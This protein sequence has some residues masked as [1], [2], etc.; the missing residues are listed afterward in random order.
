[1]SFLKTSFRLQPKAVRVATDCGCR[2]SFELKRLYVSRLAADAAP[3]A[4]DAVLGWADL[5]EDVALATWGFEMLRRSEFASQGEAVLVLW[6]E[7]AWEGGRPR[8]GFRLTARA[9]VEAERRV[10]AALD[11]A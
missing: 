9:I 10:R 11:A 5:R 4:V 8:R 2:C 6:R 1:M 3:G 7:F